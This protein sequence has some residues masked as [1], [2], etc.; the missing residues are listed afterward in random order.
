MLMRGYGTNCW[1]V[2]AVEYNRGRL[3]ETMRLGKWTRQR[4]AKVG[5]FVIFVDGRST[6]H[7][8][9]ACGKKAKLDFW[10]RGKAPSPKISQI[11]E[12]MHLHTLTRQ[13]DAGTGFF[14][15]RQ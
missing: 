1:E 8:N 2:Q 11:D 9:H 4:D 6:I 3:G 15:E 12:T 10:R 13:R 14:L 5:V 7:E